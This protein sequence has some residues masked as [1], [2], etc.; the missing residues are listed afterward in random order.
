MT[1]L[2]F[3]QL[4]RP[5]LGRLRARVG[6]RSIVKH[7]GAYEAQRVFAMQQLSRLI[8]PYANILGVAA[9]NPPRTP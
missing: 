2:L 1:Y 9:D 3:F 8:G 6:C 4:L 5:G 7:E